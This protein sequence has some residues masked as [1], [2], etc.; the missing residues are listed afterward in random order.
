MSPGMRCFISILITGSFCGSWWWWARSLDQLG[1]EDPISGHIFVAIALA[2]WMALG[3]RWFSRVSRTQALTMI[4]VGAAISRVLLVGT[5]PVLSDDLWRYLWDGEV[6][7]NGISPYGVAPEDASLDSIAKDDRW[8]KVREKINHPQIPT[9]YPPVAQGAFRF[10]AHSE[11]GWRWA[12]LLLDLGI[13]VLLCRVLIQKRSDPHRSIL[14]CWHPLPILESAIGA[15]VHFLAIMFLALALLAIENNQRWRS[16][17][18][19]SMATATLLVPA[20]LVFHLLKKVGWK[21]VAI[22][23]GGLI[24]V[25]AFY[26]AGWSYEGAQGLRAY[27][28]SWYSGGLLF[29]PL[30]K[31]LGADVYN[32]EDPLTRGLRVLLIVAWWCLAWAIRGQ[33]TWRAARL[34]MLG[35]LLLTPTLHPWYA[36]W[37]LLPTVISPCR[38]ALLLTITV[39]INYRVLDE[40]RAMGVWESPQWNALWVF[41]LPLAFLLYQGYL[42]RRQVCA[43][44]SK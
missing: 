26:W 24:A 33:E 42:N 5:D 30:G 23:V 1:P 37:L 40:W 9:V 18:F 22:F 44:P 7:R 34:L 2:L 15:H 36:L 10:F 12:M 17:G 43:T 16:A 14:W 27:A 35:F 8:A 11:R 39:L 3:Y 28:G 25:S 6:Q 20:G 41:S 4:L 31:L 21:A 13:G 29:E 19:L 32:S 38:G